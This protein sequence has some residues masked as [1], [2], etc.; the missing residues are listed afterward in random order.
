M[1]RRIKTYFLIV[2]LIF[3]SISI[4]RSIYKVQQAKARIE[5]QKQVVVKLKQEN[6]DLVKQLALV[7]SPI[8]IEKQYRDKLGLSKSGETVLILPDAEVLRRL[9]PTITEEEDI[10]PDSNWKKWW[11][12]F[13]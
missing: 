13:N 1:T 6:E 8:S 4:G 7:Q 9:A 3:L 12:L 10:L 2:V 5:A 11:K